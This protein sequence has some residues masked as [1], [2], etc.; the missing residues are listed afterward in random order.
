MSSLIYPQYRLDHNQDLASRF[1]NI[2]LT[3]PTRT[4]LTEKLR[5]YVES[6]ISNNQVGQTI[7]D[8][9]VKKGL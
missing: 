8:H 2:Y 9:E 6:N 4:T 1:K 5:H 7:D 3:L